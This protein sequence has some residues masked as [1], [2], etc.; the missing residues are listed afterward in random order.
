MWQAQG[1]MNAASK[2]ISGHLS[3]PVNMAQSV[4]RRSSAGVV[5]TWISAINQ[6]I[7]QSPSLSRGKPSSQQGKPD[8]TAYTML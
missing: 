6:T 2:S 3:E 8:V 7:P 1:L 5:A 4:N